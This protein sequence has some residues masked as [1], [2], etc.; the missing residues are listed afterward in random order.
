MTRAR[1]QASRSLINRE[2]PHRALVHADNVRGRTLNE[3]HTFHDNRGIPVKHHSLRKDDEWYSVYC[4]AE[5]GTAEAFQLLFG[6]ELIKTHSTR[7]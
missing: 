5:E 2:F 1:G 4:F 6:G 7:N 3:L